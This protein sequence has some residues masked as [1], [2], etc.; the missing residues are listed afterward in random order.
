MQFR[1]YWVN[2]R[3]S[4]GLSPAKSTGVDL[5]YESR[6]SDAKKLRSVR[7]ASREEK[8]KLQGTYTLHRRGCWRGKT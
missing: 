7:T 6:R 8:K 5:L 2:T 4:K 1:H 3:S